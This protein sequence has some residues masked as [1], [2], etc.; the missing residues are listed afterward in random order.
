M[1]QIEMQ[2]REEDKN[3]PYS[4]ETSR[5]TVLEPKR[6]SS[7]QAPCEN[8]EFC[9]QSILC[10][11]VNWNFKHLEEFHKQIFTWSINFAEFKWI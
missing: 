10:Y 9:E 6:S 7:W 1:C 5:R 2:R 4:T 11:E 8:F 3:I